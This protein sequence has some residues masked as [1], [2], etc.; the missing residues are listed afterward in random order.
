MPGSRA[1]SA[2]RAA[3]ARPATGIDPWV[4]EA[5]RAAKAPGFRRP[6][7]GPAPNAPI[8]ALGVLAALRALGLVLIAEAIAR[9]IGSLAAGD[10]SAET[11]RL[12]VIVGLAGAL[13][14]AGAEWGTAV[15]ARRI[16]TRVKRELRGR[17]WRRIVAGDAAG[18]SGVG[19]GGG[20][21][22]LAADGLDDLD[23]YYVQ[24]LPATADPS[25]STHCG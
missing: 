9:G 15:I 20:T 21:A 11:T 1:D 25:A 8:Y 12:I 16:A 19:A 22:V 3:R 5:E 18:A 4:I 17:L 24:S 13:V 6:A 2:T 10:L 7:L 23:D 14:R